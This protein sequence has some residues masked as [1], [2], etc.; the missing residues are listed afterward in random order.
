MTTTTPTLKSQ[1]HFLRY[2]KSNVF[3]VFT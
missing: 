2:S 3:N 1:C